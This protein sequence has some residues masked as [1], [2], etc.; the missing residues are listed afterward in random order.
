MKISAFVTISNWQERQDPFIECMENML[1]FADEV[2][3]VN[4]GDKPLEMHKHLKNWDVVRNK[5]VSLK[6]KWPKE[7]DWKF[8]G[9]QFQRG[10]DAC[11]GDIV[12]RMDADYFLHEN[13]FD[14]IK[15]F[16]ASKPDS[17]VYL[18]AKKQFLLT[19]RSGVKS[20]VPM[21][22]NKGKFGNRIKLDSGGDLCQPSLDGKEVNKDDCPL[23]KK[24][25]YIIIGEGVTEEQIRKRIP[26]A[27]KKI[28]QNQ[29]Y[30]H[31][32]GIHVWNMDF[33][34]KS[35]KIIKKDFGRFARAWTK[36]FNNRALGGPDDES[37]FK[38]F[39][40]MQLG[41]IKKGNWEL[42]KPEDLPKYIQDKVRNIKPSQFGYDMWG[43]VDKEKLGGAE[44]VYIW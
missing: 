17:P 31:D 6:H 32:T 15:M 11:T 43:K 44:S 28:G 33:T 36:T 35:K 7:F 23:I 22:F 19:D 8:I 12:I 14:Y 25:E 13:D 41:R 3:V 20:L 26:K 34:F 37:A 2:V 29:V 40:R 24:R 27:S 42:N 9:E 5:I 39:M 30:H 16:L 4:G 10:Y 18:L 21:V 38:Q 1:D